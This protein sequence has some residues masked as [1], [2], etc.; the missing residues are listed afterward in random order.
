M[1]MAG[2]DESINSRRVRG[3]LYSPPPDSDRWFAAEVQPHEAMLRAWLRARFPTLGDTDDL[4]QETYSRV[5]QLRARDPLRDHV[6]GRIYRITYPGRPLLEPKKIDGE[7]VA[8]LLDLLKEPENDVRLRAKIDKPYD[9]ALLHTLK[10]MGYS[11]HA[12]R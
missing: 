1:E 3:I 7:S 12:P 6:H 4:V 11:L 10:N 8:K 5:L 9:V 2:I